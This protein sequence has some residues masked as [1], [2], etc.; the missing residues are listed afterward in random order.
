MDWKTT[1]LT[2][3]IAVVGLLGN[4]M[5]LWLLGF[6]IPRNPFSV[7][8]LNLA[9][10][11]ALFLFSTFLLLLQE[12]VGYLQTPIYVV[13]VY[14]IPLAY[15]VGLSFLAAIST[16][17]CLSV[18]FPLWYK[19]KRPEHTSARACAALWALAGLFW[20]S[21]YFYCVYVQKDPFCP[22]F[23]LVRST[24]FCL[25]TCVLCVASLTLVL[26][27]QCSSQ[28]RQ[29]P[30]L[31]LLI[32]LTVLVFLLCGLPLGIGG[33]MRRLGLDI[34]PLRLVVFLA[35]VNSS[36]NPF[37][38]VFFGRQKHRKGKEE[39]LRAV[40]RRAL[41][42]EQELGSEGGDTSHTNTLETSS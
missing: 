11:D 18:L 7:Y 41:S 3:G 36:I 25:L 19:C 8:I 10:A 13:M 21:G 4:G 37:I 29:P 26:R 1:I 38:Y 31:Y 22:V 17:R 30:R 42:D 23:F 39:T 5:I 33:V 32:L 2:M 27:V 14:V 28:R 24:W 35:S 40:L 16:E 9:G 15:S 6:R 34:L 12:F 20:G